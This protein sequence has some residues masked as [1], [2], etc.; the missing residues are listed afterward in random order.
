MLLQSTLLAS[1]NSGKFSCY[2][3]NKFPSFWLVNDKSLNR[4]YRT[5]RKLPWKHRGSAKFEHKI[6][7]NGRQSDCFVIFDGLVN[8][9]VRKR[10]D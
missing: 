5:M 3:L 10:E 2:I 7:N 1:Q 4:L 9:G 6:K 8:E